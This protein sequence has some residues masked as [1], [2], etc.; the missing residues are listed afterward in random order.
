MERISLLNQS[1]I[2]LGFDM[3]VVVDVFRGKLYYVVYIDT[4]ELNCNAF[5]S[6]S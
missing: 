4:L 5:V 1:I 6:E 3:R 2:L